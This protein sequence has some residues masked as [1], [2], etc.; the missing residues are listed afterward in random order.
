MNKILF[1]F[2]M[3]MNKILNILFIFQYQIEP[4]DLAENKSNKSWQ[5]K[6]KKIKVT[7]ENT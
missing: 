5:K 2:G 6:K 3:K 4:V 7:K 1:L